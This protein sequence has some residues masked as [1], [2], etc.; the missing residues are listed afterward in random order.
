M[1]ILLKVG[2]ARATTDDHFK[3]DKVKVEQICEVVASDLF[4]N[5]IEQKMNSLFARP[6]LSKAD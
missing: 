1:F 2:I 3:A 6:M 4:I 5:W